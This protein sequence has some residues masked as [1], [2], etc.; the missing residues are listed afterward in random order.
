M[1]LADMVRHIAKVIQERNAW[2]RSETIREIRRIF[3]E[4]LEKDAS[5]ND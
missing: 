1:L 3:D 4:S 2:D 5:R